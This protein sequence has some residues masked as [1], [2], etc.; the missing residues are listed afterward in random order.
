MS[1]ISTEKCSLCWYIILQKKM[2][3][4]NL[5]FWDE[6]CTRLKGRYNRRGSSQYIGNNESKFQCSVFQARKRISPLPPLFCFYSGKGTISL[7]A[8]TNLWHL[9]AKICFF[10]LHLSLIKSFLD[11]WLYVVCCLL[12][13][14]R[15]TDLKIF[16]SLLFL[17]EYTKSNLIQKV[18]TANIKRKI[19]DNISNKS[20]IQEVLYN[21]SLL[22]LS[23][24]G[25]Y[26]M[27]S[28]QNQ[29]LLLPCDLLCQIHTLVC[30]LPVF[31][32]RNHIPSLQ[33][34]P[35]LLQ[36]ASL[37]QVEIK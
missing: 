20:E 19:K 5:W 16:S 1:I 26:F 13:Y 30:D 32:P 17:I 6:I 28:A 24:L 2:D 9:L 14:K 31:P 23:L 22:S 18:T 37:T 35:H 34:F 8:E 29:N 4:R 21:C 3:D 33:L 27:F 11:L 12:R 7:L 10:K 15:K 25:N 36:C